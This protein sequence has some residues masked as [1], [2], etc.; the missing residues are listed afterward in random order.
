MEAST[1][2]SEASEARQCIAGSRALKAV[3]DMAMCEAEDAME[4]PVS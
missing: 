1:H 2:V 3:S 4:T